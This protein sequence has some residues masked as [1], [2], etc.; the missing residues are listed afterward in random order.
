M[1]AAVE[2]GHAL[3]S[4]TE[5]AAIL[6]LWWDGEGDAL[7]IDQRDRQL[8]PQHDRRQRR[9]RFQ[10]EIIAAPLE[11][12]VGSYGHFEVEIAARAIVGARLPLASHAHARSGVHSGGDADGDAALA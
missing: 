10:H 2:L 6:G 11:L 1:S 5:D 8:T 9:V 7:A 4:D 3:A 12:W